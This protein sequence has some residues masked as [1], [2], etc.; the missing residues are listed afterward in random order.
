MICQTPGWGFVMFSHF[1]G[2]PVPMVRTGRRLSCLAALAAN[3]PTRLAGVLSCLAA[4]AATSLSAPGVPVRIE[5]RLGICQQLLGSAK[6][7]HRRHRSTWRRRAS[8]SLRKIPG[9]P[10]AS[11]R[12]FRQSTGNDRRGA[13]T[14]ADGTDDSLKAESSTSTPP[15]S[16]TRSPVAVSPSR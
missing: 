16:E 15:V 1:G 8:Q 13:I 14:A 12:G 11:R 4:L 2:G 3:G 6:I 10:V 9:I 5:A 7:K